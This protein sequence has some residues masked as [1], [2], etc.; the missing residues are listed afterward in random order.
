M[1]HRDR[2]DLR[3]F[4]RRDMVEAMDRNGWAVKRVSHPA[5]NKSRGLDWLTRGRSTEFLV[6]Q[7]YVLGVRG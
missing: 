6:A 5:L 1:G 4:T 2:T 3:W 7:W